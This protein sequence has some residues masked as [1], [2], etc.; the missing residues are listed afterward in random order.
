MFLY[1]ESKQQSFLVSFINGIL[2][3]FRGEAVLVFFL[4]VL[5][6]EQYFFFVEQVMGVGIH[7]EHVVDD[8]LEEAGELLDCEFQLD[9][10]CLQEF[11]DAEV[12]F[13][14]FQKRAFH[15][16]VYLFH[17]VASKGSSV[18]SFR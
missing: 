13:I 14:V 11:D 6:S 5:L 8:V 17:G 7:D 15:D 12:V 1:I 10:L 18:C 16:R 2:W 3:F 9:L 4:F